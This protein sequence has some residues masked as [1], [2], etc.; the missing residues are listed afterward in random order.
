MEVR[1]QEEFDQA[2]RFQREMERVFWLGGSDREVE[3]EWRWESNHELIDMNKFWRIGQPADRSGEDCLYMYVR[4]SIG[5][6]D[7][8]CSHTQPF[9]CEFD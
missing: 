3:G 7:Q 9:V 1:T 2:L 5:F 6:G 8:I 4:W